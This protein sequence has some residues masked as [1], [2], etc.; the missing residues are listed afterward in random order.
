LQATLTAGGVP[1]WEALSASAKPADLKLDA[2]VGRA[3]LAFSGTVRAL[4]R[5]DGLAGEFSLQGPSLASVG[6]PFGVTLPTTAAFDV[7]GAV[8]RSGDLWKVDVRRAQVG[9]SR[10][11]GQLAFDAGLP[12]PKL[13]GSVTGSVLKLADLV[14]AL[15]GDVQPKSASTVLPSRPFNLAALRAMDADVTLNIAQVD[16]S[17]RL[18]EPVRPFA[19]RLLLTGGVL[20]LTEIDARTA[21]GH[22]QGTVALDGTADIAHW[23]AALRWDG[24][25]LQRWIRQQRRAGL[26]PYVS[27]LLQGHATLQGTGRSTAELLATLHGDISARVTRGSVSHLLVEAGGLDVAEVLGVLVRGDNPLRLD[28]AVAELTIDKG[29][30]RPRLLVLDTTDSTAWLDGDVSLATETLNLR[31]VTAPK[32]FSVLTLRSPLHIQGSFA[33]PA[34][35]IE[36]GPVGAKLGAAVLLGLINPLAAILPLM[37]GGGKAEANARAAACLARLR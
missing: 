9:L 1:P 31:A 26:P 12:V 6:A 36:K 10:L 7:R 8:Q 5:V 37:D 15:G 13:S 25:Q 3:R 33:Q 14:P 21:Q 22:L 19:A 17:T 27:G 30:V 35:S 32:D 29:V 23:V 20:S 18:L 28:C 11:A 4:Q 2:T 24:V 16:A 34:I